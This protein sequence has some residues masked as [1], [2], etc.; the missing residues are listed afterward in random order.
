[1]VYVG[2]VRV[3]V[4]ERLMNVR[5]GMGLLAVPFRPVRVLVMLI[6]S[7][8]MFVLNACVA[9]RMGVLFR[10]MQPDPEPH[11]HARSEQRCGQRSAQRHRER[12]AD[13]GSK[14]EI[15]AGPCRPQMAQCHHEKSQAESVSGKPQ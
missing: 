14:R 2:K 3:C 5:V 7:M 1:M 11:E 12:R 4:L 13:K 10:E 8:R 6:V 9:M 15:G